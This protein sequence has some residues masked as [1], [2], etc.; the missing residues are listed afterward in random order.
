VGCGLWTG[1]SWFWI[2]RGDWHL[3]MR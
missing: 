1:L 3:C 2:E